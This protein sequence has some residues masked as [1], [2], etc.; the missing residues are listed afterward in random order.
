[1][2]NVTESA[3]DIDARILE[4]LD[5]FDDALLELQETLPNSDRIIDACHAARSAYTMA[6]L[7]RDRDG[8][9]VDLLKLS[10]KMRTLRKILKFEHPFDPNGIQHE[11]QCLEFR[12]T[13]LKKTRQGK[14]DEVSEL[15]SH[16]IEEALSA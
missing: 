3:E 2:I 4:S 5:E 10:D 14:H 12:E 1:M 6:F 16:S 9:L 7:V 13:I 15:L 8:E 11:I